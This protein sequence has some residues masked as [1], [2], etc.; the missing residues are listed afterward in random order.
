MK[1]LKLKEL[2]EGFDPQSSVNQSSVP[3][4]EKT[5]SPEERT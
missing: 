5:W 1:I 3:P 2:I 4:Q